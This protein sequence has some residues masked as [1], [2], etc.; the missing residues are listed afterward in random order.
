MKAGRVTVTAFFL[1]L[2]LT[3]FISACGLLPG[4]QTGG[5]E[6]GGE[7]IGLRVVYSSGDIRWIGSMEWVAEEFMKKYP[8]IQVTLTA[9]AD[10]PGQSFTD[11]LKVLIAQDEFYD[12]VELREAVQFFLDFL[13]ED[14][15]GYLVTN[16]SSS[17][18]NTYMLPT[19]EC[20]RLCDG[21]A[22]DNEIL[23]QLT[24][25][26]LDAAKVLGMS[27]PLPTRTTWDLKGTVSP[28]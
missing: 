27:D 28:V 21:P 23:W 1:W 8:Q 13:T 10:V 22:M 5:E 18:E 20:G 11:R 16:P 17:P 3:L 24:G 2:G 6:D 9:P 14:E 19:G 4:A 12:V 25:D 7:P 15:E 26:F